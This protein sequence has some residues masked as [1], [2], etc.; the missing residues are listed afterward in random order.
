MQDLH[1]FP[2]FGASHQ[3]G[4]LFHRPQGGCSGFIQTGAFNNLKAPTTPSEP[5]EPFAPS[6]PSRPQGVSIT[7]CPSHGKTPRTFVLGVLLI[8]VPP[9]EGAGIISSNHCPS[10]EQSSGL[11]G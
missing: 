5:C 8:P 1:S 4:P 3:R 11:E 6:E 7:A 2:P 10:F 9:G